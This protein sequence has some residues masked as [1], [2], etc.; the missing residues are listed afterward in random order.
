MKAA[1]FLLHGL[2][3]LLLRDRTQVPVLQVGAAQLLGDAKR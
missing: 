3:L 1:E 2:A